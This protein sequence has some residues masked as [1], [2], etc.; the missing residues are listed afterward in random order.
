[1]EEKECYGIDCAWCFEECD[2]FVE[3]KEDEK[4]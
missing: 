2:I 4:E 3:K 1:M